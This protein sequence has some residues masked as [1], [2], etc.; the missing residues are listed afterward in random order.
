MF[1][2]TDL[3]PRIRPRCFGVNRLSH[4][5]SGYRLGSSRDVSHCT[6]Y[7]KLRPWKGLEWNTRQMESKTRQAPGWMEMFLLETPADL[8]FP[9]FF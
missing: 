3:I 6:K 1:I 4:P 5:F 8:N 2:Q 7:I 9:A